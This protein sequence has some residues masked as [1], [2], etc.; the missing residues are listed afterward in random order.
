MTNPIT[1]TDYKASSIHGKQ[2][3]Y[4]G[5]FSNP[6]GGTPSVSF[7]EELIT[8]DGTTDTV[9]RNQAGGC[10]AT[11][12]DATKP[13]TLRSPV[14]DSIIAHSAFISKLQAQGTIT[15]E[16]FFLMFY[17]LG[18]GAQ[19]ARDAHIAAQ[20][21]QAVAQAA[22]DADQSEANL[23]ALNSAIAATEAAIGEM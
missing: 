5:K 13:L 21:A 10:Q 14:D 4:G 23:A 22:Y 20:K 2:R 7:D 16:D 9:F 6:M 17:S 8:Y 1:V 12:T 19:S 11:L 3:I 18:R 15:N